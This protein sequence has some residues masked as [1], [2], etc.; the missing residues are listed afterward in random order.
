MED[1][2]DF[3]TWSV[4]EVNQVLDTQASRIICEYFDIR[5]EGDM[6]ENPEKNVLHISKRPAQ[7]ATEMDL[8]AAKVEAIIDE[9]CRKMLAAREQRPEPFIDSSLYVNWNGMMSEAFFEAGRLLER[10]SLTELALKT[11]Q[12]IW[13]EAWDDKKGFRHKLRQKRENDSGPF[14][15][16]H[17]FYA[18]ASLSAFERTGDRT[19]LRRAQQV[20]DKA[21]EM[22]WNE[23][24][25]G[26]YDTPP[27][28]NSH[29]FLS[30]PSQPIQD[31]PTPG[32]N[33]VAALVLQR[34]FFLSDNEKYQN[35]AEKTL[36][37][38]AGT[39]GQYGT[40]SATFGLAVA[41]VLKEPLHILVIADEESELWNAALKARYPLEIIQR[42]SKNDD[43]E[44]MPKVAQSVIENMTLEGVS[45]ALICTA[46]SC[47]Q[48]IYDK[49]VLRERLA[50]L[51]A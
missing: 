31:S 8:D 49:N 3:W 5:P 25:G 2:G 45:V 34:L 1:D 9:S 6:H 15:G 20:M 18:R 14:L 19:H 43:F 10:E 26:F 48:P 44:T 35:L 12:R 36:E 16:D 7:I 27:A 23:E 39:V 13:D 28:E 38:F 21:Y 40:F 33:A 47:T 32:E 4:D 17:V 11:L 42:Y 37:R 22:L 30:I 41:Q 29:G 50:E 51:R 46:T 24:Q